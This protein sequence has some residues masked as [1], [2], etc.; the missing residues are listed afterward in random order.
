LHDSGRIGP[1]RRAGP[2]VA[3]RRRGV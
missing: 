1:S 3:W 2:P